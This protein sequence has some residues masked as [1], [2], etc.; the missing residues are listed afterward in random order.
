MPRDSH[1]NDL[2]HYHT[3][4]KVKHLD[5]VAERLR[6][7]A[8][9]FISP[10]VLEVPRDLGFNQGLAIADLDGHVLHLVA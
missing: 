7:Q 4:I 1:A 6:K 8:C 9:N 5:S 3:T 10:G 2:W